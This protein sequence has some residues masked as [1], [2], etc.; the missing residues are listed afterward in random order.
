MAET[1]RALGSQKAWLVHGLDGTDEISICGPTKVAMLADGR[2]SEATIKPEDAGLPEHPFGHILGGTPQEN[3]AKVRALLAGDQSAGVLAFRHAVMLNAAA[4]LLIADK[5]GSL[6]EGATMAAAAID[7]GR[8]LRNLE[9][10][11]AIST[12]KT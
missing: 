4:A 12:A 6:A 11:V 5:A 7:K 3:T 10:I 8:S 9:K 1:L 2:V